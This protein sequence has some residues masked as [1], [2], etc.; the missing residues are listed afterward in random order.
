MPP[1]PK[2]RSRLP[3]LKTSED[4]ARFKAQLQALPT[5]GAF[6]KQTVEASMT[7]AVSETP[8]TAENVISQMDPADQMRILSASI[9]YTRTFAAVGQRGARLMMEIPEEE[10]ARDD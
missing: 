7:A 8:E 9:T 4:L 6:A 5:L 10:F 3:S 2:R 1:T